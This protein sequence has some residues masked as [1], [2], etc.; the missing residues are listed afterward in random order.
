[1]LLA[2]PNTLP[3]E[4]RLEGQFQMQV[5]SQLNRYFI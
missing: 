5:G 4:R 1:M 3:L 2:Y